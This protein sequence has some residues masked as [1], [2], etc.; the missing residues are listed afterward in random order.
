[1]RTVRGAVA[2][3]AVILGLML[4]SGANAQSNA[5]RWYAHAAGGI[6]FA[7]DLDWRQTNLHQGG[8]TSS[9]TV[10]MG[11]ETGWLVSGAVGYRATDT[12]RFELEGAY[13]TNDL[14]SFLT[15]PAASGP[16]GPARSGK[17]TATSL[18]ASVLYDM[19]TGTAVR[20][21]IG[22]GVGL[23]KVS[24]DWTA[25]G[26]G[27]D[28][29]E[30]KFVIQ[31]TVGVSWAFTANLEAFGQYEAFMMPSTNSRATGFAGGAQSTFDLGTNYITHSV[32]FG[33][34]YAF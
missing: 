17:L 2:L 21:Y 19:N 29:D 6:A 26:V 25:G 9:A 32:L 7:A 15:V 10:F 1:M 20:P 22:P 12:I 3:G 4:A 27:F 30:W 14:D 23:A 24:T 5:G 28:D 18:V 31:A 13:R 11:Y 33:L 34:R 8:G 16:A